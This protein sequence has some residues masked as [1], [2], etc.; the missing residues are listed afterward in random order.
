MEDENPNLNS[1][2]SSQCRFVGRKFSTILFRATSTVQLYS[3]ALSNSREDGR[4][5]INFFVIR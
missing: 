2:H 5:S 1:G 4:F 3:R